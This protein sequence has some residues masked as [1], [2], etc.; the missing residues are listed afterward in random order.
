LLA[1]PMAGG[2]STSA[3]VRAV[4]DA[5]A[6]GFLAAG[7][8]SPQAVADEIAAVR[9]ARVPFGVNVFVPNPIS[10]DAEDFRRY[11]RLIQPE[12]DIYGL[13]LASSDP[14]ENDD[15]WN[16]KI[17]LL[18]D[19]PVPVVSFTFA[20][21]GKG[22]VASLRN[23]GTVVLQT[24]TS[25]DEA[26]LAAEARPDMLVVQAS[27]AGA[28]SGTFT[29]LKLPPVIPIRQ[30]LSAVRQAVDLPLV[31]AGGISTSSDVKEVLSAGASSA[32]LGTAFVRC[33]ESG[34][35]GVYK[36]TLRDA[37]GRTETLVTRAFTGRPARAIRNRFVELYDGE[38]PSGYP[39]LH[40]LT[41]PLRKAAA[42]AGD[43]DRLNLW[44]GTGYHLALDQPAAQVVG[45]LAAEL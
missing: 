32:M 40:Y 1:A 9:S 31:A 26:R 37:A 27:A 25:P 4:A 39:A 33:E 35:S 29:P 13:D 14:I 11:A 38:A 3:L 23:A 2:P 30:L 18:I 45:R 16:D 22:V 21:P 12:G 41:S 5:G 6:L 7:Y 34:A 42:A 19:D 20:V 28:H 15:Q 24:V 17:A 10:V 44:A 36:D 8:K 43:P